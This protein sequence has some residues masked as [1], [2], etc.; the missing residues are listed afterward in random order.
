[1]LQGLQPADHR[2]D[3]RAHL[4]ILVH[5]GGAL[6][7]ERFVAGTQRAILLAQMLQ[8]GEQLIDALA[9]ARELE[10]ELIFCSVA[11]GW[12]IEPHS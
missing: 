10:I 7:G 9:E 2:L 6:A 11:H 5:E 1:M 4:L 3:T 12:T 8:H